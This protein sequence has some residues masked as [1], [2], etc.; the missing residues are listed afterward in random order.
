[1]GGCDKQYQTCLESLL[2]RAATNFGPV[3]NAYPSWIDRAIDENQITYRMN[4]RN[5]N[6]QLNQTYS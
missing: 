1:M 3:M 5:K 6:I 4:K 2:S